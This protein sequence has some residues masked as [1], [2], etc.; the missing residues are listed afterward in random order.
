MKAIVLAGG[1]ARRLWPLTKETPKPLLPIAGKPMIDYLIEKLSS[2]DSIDTIYV[3]V[4][5]R[6][7]PHFDRW[8]SGSSFQKDVEVFSEESMAE[9]EKLGA[10]GALGLILREKRIDDDVLVV[11]GDNLFDFSIDTFLSSHNG[12]PL[13]ALYDMENLEK[14]RG[15]Y[16]VVRL[17]EGN[18]I[19]E[20]R[21]KPENPSTTL[22]STGCYFLPKCSV[23]RIHDYLSEG[24]NPDAPGFFISWLASK[25]MVGGFVFDSSHKWFDIGSIECY[26]EANSCLSNKD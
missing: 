9:N 23:C 3:S 22:V 10:I 12:R 7:Q 17:G 18:V 15:K 26:N 16:G 13:V 11:A 20:F 6:F 8:A 5:R 21:E 24:G 4:N 2:V 1:F 14:V 19:E 25:T